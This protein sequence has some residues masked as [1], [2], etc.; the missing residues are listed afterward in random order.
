MACFT[1]LHQQVG[2]AVQAHVRQA[3]EIHVKQFTQGALI[4]QPVPGG[5]FGSR[6][7]HAANEIAEDAGTHDTVDA[8][9]GQFIDKTELLQRMQRDVLDANAARLRLLQGID[10][11]LLE[12]RCGWRSRCGWGREI[13]GI[14]HAIDSSID[15]RLLWWQ[16]ALDQLSNVTLGG[17]LDGRWTG[18]GNQNCL[19][20]QQ[21]SMRLHGPVL[22]LDGEVATEI[23]N[24][25]L[26]HLTADALATHQAKGVTP[27]RWPCC[28]FWSVV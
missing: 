17:A 21:S 25:D 20:L 23:E 8:Q 9:F 22:P 1:M 7:R 14:G 27:R 10:V 18:N 24:G 6:L 15:R 16:G 26:T 5:Q 11:D 2:R 4:L 13:G 28:W 12:V 3:R 19:G